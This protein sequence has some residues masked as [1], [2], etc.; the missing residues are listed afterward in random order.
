M[1]NRELLC[2]NCGAELSGPYCHECGQRRQSL[3]E[4]VKALLAEAAEVVFDLDNA[5]LRTVK[6]LLRKPG[7]LTLDYLSGKRMRYVRP[8][9]LYLLTSVIYFAA[10]GLS[11]RR[12]MLF[13]TIEGDEGAMVES[14]VGLLPRIMVVMVP[15]FALVLKG[16]L[17]RRLYVEHLVF[18]VHV[19][20][21]WFLFYTADSLAQPLAASLA[22]GEITAVA[23]LAAAVSAS[24]QLGSLAHLFIAIRRVYEVSRRRAALLWGMSLGGY[25]AILAMIVMLLIRLVPGLAGSG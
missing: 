8:A 5:I 13:V 22:V 7:A 3:V 11:V 15:A 21:A 18:A 19:H 23:L 2:A 17:R 6:R 4:P 12:T 14:F 24:A 1:V 25:F 9:R 20:A 16:L 10:A